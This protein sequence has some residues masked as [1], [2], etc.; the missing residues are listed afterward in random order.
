MLLTSQVGVIQEWR[1]QEKNASW[2][3]TETHVEDLRFF[4]VVTMRNIAFW[5]INTQFVPHRKHITS[6]LQ[7]PNA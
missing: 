2:K 1:I 5:D 7:S 3:C 4:T 6:Q